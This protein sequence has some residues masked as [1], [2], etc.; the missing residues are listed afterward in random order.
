MVDVDGAPVNLVTHA[1][2]QGYADMNFIIPELIDSVAFMKGPYFAELGDLSS[3]GAAKISTVD[4]LRDPF[5]KVEAGSFGYTRAVTGVSYEQPNRGVVTAAAEGMIYDGP[6]DLEE[7]LTKGNF[8]LGY[9]RR[10]N[11]LGDI[12]LSLLAYRGIWNSPDQIPL[13]A[14]D[15]GLLDRTGSIDTTSGGS[16]YR[17]GLTGNYRINDGAALYSS[18]LYAFIYGLDLFSNFTYFLEDSIN[19]DQFKQSDRRFTTGGNHAVELDSVLFG[20][21]SLIEV[22]IQHRSDF[23][24]TVALE[25]TRQRTTIAEIRHDSVREHSVGVYVKNRY[26]PLSLLRTEVGA[27]GDI[28]AFDVDSSI[29]ENSGQRY[30]ARFSP[31]G[32]LT[33]GPWRSNELFLNG[34]FGFHSNDARGTTISKDPV[35]GTTVDPVTP[36]VRSRGAEIGVRSRPSTRTTTTLA[37]WYLD[38]ASELLFIGDAGTT[39]PSG[40]SRRRGVEITNSY[41][42]LDWA[43]VELEGA[44][45]HSEFTDAVDDTQGRKI[46]GALPTVLGSGLSLGVADGPFANIRL[47]YFGKRPLIEDNSVRSQPSTMLSAR[48]GYRWQRVELFAEG[49]NLLDRRDNDIDYFY[50]SRLP[51]EP[52]AGVSDLHFHPAE[53][54]ALR[55]GITVK[56]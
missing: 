2:G 44:Y 3:A 15:Q 16:S 43:E 40:A 12:K 1:H 26:Q 8:F 50:T 10:N 29:Q 35:Q 18:N 46:P 52:S 41:R 4:R 25:R 9:S 20:A 47:R 7:D 13:R 36:L 53:P 5:L 28:F 14:V 38:L 19:G 49:F 24:P 32:G 31:K 39:E 37:A 6:W 22:G 56:L 23:I 42:I 34:G 21:E 17:Y 54:F 30:A 45:T 27:R 48:M 11:A 33:I 55:L 51:G